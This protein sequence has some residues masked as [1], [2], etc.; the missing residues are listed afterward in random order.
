MNLPKGRNR[1]RRGKKPAK[2]KSRPTSNPW[3]EDSVG[4]DRQLNVTVAYDLLWNRKFPAPAAL[5]L[6]TSSHHVIL[7]LSDKT[8]VGCPWRSLPEVGK[9]MAHQACRARSF[10][11]SGK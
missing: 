5:Y 4:K 1:I 6:T 7:L 2:K 8:T 11:F 3:N 9:A 10:Y